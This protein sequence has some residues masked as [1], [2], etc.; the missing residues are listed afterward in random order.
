MYVDEVIFHGKEMLNAM[1]PAQGQDQVKQRLRPSNRRSTGASPAGTRS[2][3]KTSCWA[4]SWLRSRPGSSRCFNPSTIELTDASSA[5]SFN[6]TERER[7]R[8]LAGPDGVRHP[9]PVHRIGSIVALSGAR[10]NAIHL[11]RYDLRSL[12]P[13]DSY[14][15]CGVAERFG[16]IRCYPRLPG[17]FAGVA[18]GLRGCFG[19]AP[20]GGVGRVP[21]FRGFTPGG[22][23]GRVPGGVV[24]GGRGGRDC[25]KATVDRR[26]SAQDTS[27]RIRFTEHLPR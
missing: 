23:A 12:S 27:Q 24:F 22:G 17:G 19:R 13:T 20:G 14:G 5:R 16:A 6:E 11:K 26:K 25:A 21:G 2:C 18:G 8:A 1:G 3:E 15:G 9:P 4:A 10:S 7:K